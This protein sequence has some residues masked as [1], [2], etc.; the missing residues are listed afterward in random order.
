[1]AAGP[2]ASRPPRLSNG[3]FMPQALSC[4][5]KRN[6]RFPSLGWQAAFRPQHLGIYRDLTLRPCRTDVYHARPMQVPLI[7]RLGTGN[8]S[9]TRRDAGNREV[10]TGN[11]GDRKVQTCAHA[12]A[13]AAEKHAPS[14]TAEMPERHF[15]RVLS[16]DTGVVLVFVNHGEGHSQTTAVC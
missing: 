10:G 1:M 15:D 8:H 6:P 4:S 5:C 2:G 13:H 9:E 3:S 14:R 7:T 16:E 11:V 12:H